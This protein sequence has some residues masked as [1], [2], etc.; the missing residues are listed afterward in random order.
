MVTSLQYEKRLLELRSG[1]YL[2]KTTDTP[3][4][5]SLFNRPNKKEKVEEKPSLETFQ[6]DA[7]TNIVRKNLKL[8]EM[9]NDPV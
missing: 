4:K 2:N 8:K 3:P 7:F 5:D 9:L 6:Q 1:E